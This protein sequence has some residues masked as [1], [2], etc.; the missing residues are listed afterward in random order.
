MTKFC[1][2]CAVPLSM[3][4]MKGPAEDYCKHCTDAQGNLKSREEVKKGFA[5][6]LKTWQPGIDDQTALKRAEHYMLA[7]PAWA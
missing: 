3:P 6:W 7:M 5:E 2:S 1:L 4:D